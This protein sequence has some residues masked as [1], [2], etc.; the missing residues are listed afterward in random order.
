MRC[1]SETGAG[2]RRGFTLLELLA[3]MAIIVIV[4]GISVAAFANITRGG[5]VTTVAHRVRALVWQA[6]SYAAGHNVQTRVLF[7]ISASAR[8]YVQVQWR[9]SAADPW[10]L[11]PVSKRY[12]MTETVEFYYDGGRPVAVLK[13]TGKVVD[14]GARDT[15]PN[16]LSNEL[17]FGPT[18]GLLPEVGSPLG[19]NNVQIG[20]IHP[21]RKLKKAVTVLFASGL[22]Y[23]ED[24]Q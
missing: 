3:V 24:A 12:D 7:G 21:K 19:T 17:V 11:D 16:L 14:L 5:A 8:Q 6:R 1:R 9:S 15:D 4:A 18:G 20:F 22:P 10:G 23:V 13:R 2:A